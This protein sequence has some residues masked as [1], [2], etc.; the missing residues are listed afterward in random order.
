MCIKEAFIM[1]DWRLGPWQ[2]TNNVYIKNVE[3]GSVNFSNGRI[4]VKLQ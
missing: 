2:I 3:K 4:K 1:I